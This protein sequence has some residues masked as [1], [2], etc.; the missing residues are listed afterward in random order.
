MN[1]HTPT[2]WE[3]FEYEGVFHID[4]RSET[5]RA[6]IAQTDR[7]NGLGKE[8]NKANAAF[9][10]RACNNYEKAMSLLKWAHEELKM[11]TDPDAHCEHE[12][13]ICACEYF[14]KRQQMR[15]ILS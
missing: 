4:E 7:H 1:K 10:V 13:G 15:D 6:D 9:I 3:M 5:G 12:I 14:S 8:E 11:N 2:P